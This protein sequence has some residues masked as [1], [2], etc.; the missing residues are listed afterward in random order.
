MAQIYS[1]SQVAFTFT[2]ERLL[3]SYE[4]CYFWTFTWIGVYPDWWYGYQWNRFMLCFRTFFGR[5]I[6]GVRVVEISPGGHGLHFHAI[7]NRRFNV[8]M[9]RR[10]GRR[11]GIGRVQVARVDSGT[12]K[13]MIKYMRKAYARPIG[14]RVWGCIGGWK[15]SRKNSIQV[16]SPFHRNMKR[17]IRRNVRLGFNETQKVLAWSK[18][19]GDIKDW[20]INGRFNRGTDYYLRPTRRYGPKK[21]T[22][23]PF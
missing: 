18:A 17:L 11:F 1:K 21:Y 12:V 8:N 2:A 3:E 7:L 23:C 5:G 6:R 14:V 16:D 19:Y 20:P 22:N 13:Y 15:S 10:I 9:V 4:N